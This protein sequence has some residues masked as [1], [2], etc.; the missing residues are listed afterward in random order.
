MT[1]EQENGG[2]AA[3]P[4]TSG[5]GS[6]DKS[7]ERSVS[8]ESHR[9]LLGEKKNLASKLDG[10]LSKLAEYE[11]EKEAATQAKLEEE[12][13][14]REL[15][16]E[17][18]RKRQET[19]DTLN[20]YKTQVENS[21]KFN[22]LKSTLGAEIPYK[23]ASILDFSKI[24]MTDDNVPEE[25]SVT[26]M[27]EFVRKEYPEIVIKSEA[28]GNLPNNAPQGNQGKLSVEEWKKLPLKE[29]KDRMA[30]VYSDHVTAQ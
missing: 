29:R 16:E 7:Q 27:C 18:K 12:G 3:T 15:L 26:E 30:E 8:Y 17:E 9:K 1:T 11:A 4:E 6:E 22:A 24:K 13:R 28:G 14:F 2:G 19:E 25:M 21:V 23:Y 20:S 10:A 5:K